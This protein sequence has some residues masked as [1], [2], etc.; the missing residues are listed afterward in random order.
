MTS[1]G[2]SK[3]QNVSIPEDYN[4]RKIVE[5]LLEVM[6]SNVQGIGP[7]DINNIIQAGKKT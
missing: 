6:H 4:L 2:M 1:P 3:A 7:N 5:K